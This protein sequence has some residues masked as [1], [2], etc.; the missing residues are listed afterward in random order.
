METSKTGYLVNIGTTT[1]PDYKDLSELFQPL[2]SGTTPAA[3]TE[4][5]FTV[6]LKD[7]NT[8]F[9]KYDGTRDTAPTTNMIS[10]TG[11]DLNLVFN[12]I[13]V[14]PT[15]YTVTYN[16]NGNTSG[17]APIDS[18]SPYIAGSTVTVLDSGTIA[19]TGYTFASWN[20]STDGSGTSYSPADTFT[21]NANTT[22]YAQ[23]TQ[24]PIEFNV[25]T[26]QSWTK[27]IQLNTNSGYKAYLFTPP[28][29][30]FD[31][32]VGTAASFY[33]NRD[34][35]AN[36]ILVG[37]GSGAGGSGA[38]AGLGNGGG[39]GGC[40]TS[41][42]KFY[43]ETRYPI[44]VGIGGTG[45]TSDD[46]GGTSGGASTLI[47]T[48]TDKTFTAE[49]GYITPMPG[50]YLFSGN[51]GNAYKTSD[52][53][54]TFV[55][56]GG[57]GGGAQGNINQSSSTTGVVYAGGF[58][59]DGSTPSNN[60][61]AGKPNSY[62]AGYTSYGGYGGKSGPT[63]G[64]IYLPFASS[65]M[66]VG[67][68]GGGGSW[69]YSSKN[70]YLYY[71]G[72]AGLGT[73]GASGAYTDKTISNANNNSYNAFTVNSTTGLAGGYGNGGGATNSGNSSSASG[74]QGY[75]GNGCFII[76]WVTNQ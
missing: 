75:G 37:A 52:M 8:I 23:W 56:Y 13:N 41:P 46:P 76:W 22:L 73:G 38:G 17:T 59:G 64:T 29:P 60:G 26:D 65:Y 74:D 24:T 2:G 69:S 44:T 39:G 33:F 31:Q 68:G 11:R 43:A 71:S 51:G 53:P 42:F 34:V 28:L 61:T 40:I 7:L 70:G 45:V 18:S 47:Y 6:G 4:T 63:N 67:G 21:I 10:L 19:Q 12:S 55:T 62:P 54:D 66:S 30:T 16:G 35:S 5:G 20:T 3:D 50:Y 36:I 15:T 1:T 48:T 9:A 32:K 72:Y 27:A 57:G 14:T 25:E 58:G 49:G